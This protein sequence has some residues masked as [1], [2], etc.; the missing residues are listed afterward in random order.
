MFYL[1]VGLFGTTKGE[2]QKVDPGIF[3]SKVKSS[4]DIQS[5]ERLIIS[6]MR[7]VERD[8]FSLLYAGFN[9]NVCVFDWKYEAL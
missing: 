9:T 4:V 7:V 3:P 8:F 1:Y 2:C 5:I 6:L